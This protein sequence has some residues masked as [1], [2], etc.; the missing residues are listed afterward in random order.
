MSMKTI[1]SINKKM[2]E[3][4][5]EFLQKELEEANWVQ[6]TSLA[7]DI[8]DAITHIEHKLEYYQ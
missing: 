3:M 6:D 7:M 2:L 1:R 5:L 4:Q 8:E